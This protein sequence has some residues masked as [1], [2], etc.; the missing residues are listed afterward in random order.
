MAFMVIISLITYYSYRQLSEDYL[1]LNRAEAMGDDLEMI[2]RSLDEGQAFTRGYVITGDEFYFRSLDNASEKALKELEELR[3]KINSDPKLDSLF[4]SLSENVKRQLLLLHSLANRYRSTG[5]LNINY[6]EKLRESHAQLDVVKSIH[7]SMI[8]QLDPDSE[9]GLG[10]SKTLTPVFIIIGYLTS[11]AAIV[12]LYIHLYRSLQINLATEL[13]LER[14]LIELG[15]EIQEREEAEKLTERIL[16]SSESA[17]LHLRPI[18]K[19][20]EVSDFVIVKCNRQTEIQGGYPKDFLQ[21]KHMIETFPGARESGLFDAYVTTLKT[22]VEYKSEVLY[23]YDNIFLY[24]CIRAVTLGD[25]LVITS[26]DISDQEMAKREIERN[27]QKFATL[28]HQS[29]QYIA[30]INDECEIT[31]INDSFLEFIDSESD[32]IGQCIFELPIWS[33]EVSMMLKEMFMETLVSKSMRKEAMIERPEKEES[34]LDFSFTLVPGEDSPM[35]IFEARDITDLHWAQEEHAFLAHLNVS[36]TNAESFNHAANI[37]FNKIGVRYD[38]ESTEVWVPE[39]TRYV[40]LLSQYLFDPEKDDVK[41]DPNRVNL[42]PRDAGIVGKVIREKCM[43]YEPDIASMNASEM[44]RKN[45]LL[46]KGYKSL[47][48]VPIV[49][50]NEVLLV[51]IFLAD[52]EIEEIGELRNTLQIMSSS[53]GALLIKKKVQDELRQNNFI[54]REAEKMAKLGSWEWHLQ[55]NTI[56]WSEGMYRIF[57]MPVNYQ[58]TYSDFLNKIYPQDRESVNDAL[59]EAVS[60][61]KTYEID[62]RLIVSDW[63]IK[64]VRATGHPLQNNFG[65]VESY[66]GTIQ[67]ISAQKNHEIQLNEK[68]EELKDTNKNLEQF[69]YIASHDLQ[70]PLRKIRAFGDRLQTKYAEKLGG[71]GID[72]LERMQNA[73]ERMQTLINDL[74]KYSRI[75]RNLKPF[76]STDLTVILKGVLSDLEAVIRDREAEILTG[77]LPVIVGDNLQIRQLLQNLITNAI[78]FVPEGRKPKVEIWSEPVSFERAQQLSDNMY[79][80]YISLFIRDNGIGVEQKYQQR[81]FGLFER[82]HGRSEYTGTGIGLAICQRVVQNHNGFIEVK[83][84]NGEGTTFEIVLPIGNIHKHKVEIN[85]ES[86]GNNDSYS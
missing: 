28:F 62:F 16:D 38:L 37:I 5:S 14:N 27:H 63:T 20:G 44:R 75:A 51:A 84:D 52:Q 46:G 61:K 13:Q 26:T 81:I 2:V 35:I 70:E 48:A 34:Y 21:N 25:G 39:G 32:L 85:D 12:F 47:F 69:A 68:N 80:E 10:L 83:S 66:T 78:K 6:L 56:K 73:A 33:E 82:L 11:V 50:E 3:T 74:L 22:G 29:F 30:L 77:D 15:Q 23:D 79:T 49:F 57:D 55:D 59:M 8:Q 45:F 1:K 18:Y 72:Y 53:L 31:E 58:P 65:K 67:D 41:I 64:Y 43:I 86:E 4:I 54:L 76:Q 60:A 9:E 36:I 40:R 42:L 71:S 7:E 24:L 17:I 19:E